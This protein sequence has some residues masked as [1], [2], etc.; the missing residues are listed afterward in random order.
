MGRAYFARA[1]ARAHIV[2]NADDPAA[3]LIES[4]KDAIE[5]VLL[6]VFEKAAGRVGAEVCHLNHAG[7]AAIY[8]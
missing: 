3:R 5:Q 2:A 4:P 1:R 6:A 7:Q 8:K